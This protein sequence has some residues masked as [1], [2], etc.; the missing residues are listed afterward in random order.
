MERK[1]EARYL[2]GH[3]EKIAKR[4]LLEQYKKVQFSSGSI[5]TWYGEKEEVIMAR[6][7][8]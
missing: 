3:Y 1:G 6:N 2:K 7:V 5:D 8:Q 4:Y